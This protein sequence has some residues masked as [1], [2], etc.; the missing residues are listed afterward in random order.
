MDASSG[1]VPDGTSWCRAVTELQS[2]LASVVSGDEVRVAGGV[3]QPDP[4]SGQTPEDRTA[5]FGLNIGIVLLGGCV[6]SGVVDPGARDVVTFE[7]IRTGAS[8]GISLFL[9]ACGS[10]Q[11]SDMARPT[12]LGDTRLEPVTSCAS[13][14]E[15]SS[16]SSLTSPRM[17]FFVRNC[18]I[19]KPVALAPHWRCG[20]ATL[21]LERV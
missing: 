3:Y 20:G 8:G 2:A 18:A 12:K 5:S 13:S 19:L 11:L 16:Q 7:R 21:V 15:S 9:S 10:T 14:R 17:Q 1:G 4:G 6:G